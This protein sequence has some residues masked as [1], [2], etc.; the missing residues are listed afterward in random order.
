VYAAAG[1]GD[2]G[3]DERMIDE[4]YV[5]DHVIRGDAAG[6]REWAVAEAGTKRA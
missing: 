5:V 6:D 2:P 1:P 3:G 4:T